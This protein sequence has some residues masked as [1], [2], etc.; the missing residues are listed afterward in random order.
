MKDAIVV[1]AGLAGLN[2]SAILERAGLDITLLEASDAPGGRVR[3]DKVDGF[4]LDRGFQVLLTAYPEAQRA[5][6]YLTL[7]LKELKPGALVRYHGHFHDFADPFREPLSAMNLIFDPIVSFT[8]KRLVAKLRSTVLNGTPADLFGHEESTTREYL[9]AFGFSPKIIERFFEPFFGG[10]FLEKE[11]VTSSRYFEFLFR[12][13]ATEDVAVP[14]RG[15]GEISWQLAAL[16]KPG[17]LVTNARV[18]KISRTSDG[19]AIETAAHEGYSSR[20]LVVATAEPQARALLAQM[21]GAPAMP[22]PHDWNRTTTFYFAAERAP[23]E[24]RILILNGEG[25]SAGP[26]NNAVVMSNVSRACAPHGAHLISASVIGEAPYT[27]EQLSR[28]EQAVRQHM[29]SWFG[30]QVDLWRT[31]RAYPIEY[32]VTCEKSAVWEGLLPQSGSAA[33][34]VCGDFL[35]TPSIQGALLSGRRAAE[36]LQKL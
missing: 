25:S 16:L 32:A 11:L 19:F 36:K 15:M 8:D 4:L 14:E 7:D 31:L 5:L 27:E 29:K 24:Q 23:I 34:V 35:E 17:T 10:V 9:T 21:E 20:A 18:E 2:C 28:L 30:P 33:L 3:T 1:G 12:M 22:P 26:V 6:D 13:F